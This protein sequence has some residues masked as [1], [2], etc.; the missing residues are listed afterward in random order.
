[1]EISFAGR[2]GGQGIQTV[3]KQQSRKEILEEKLGRVEELWY[4][5][6][7]GGQCLRW[8]REAAFP[9]KTV[10]QGHLKKKVIATHARV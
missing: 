1:M 9:S 5:L 3:E 6:K 7:E 8:F 2:L 4:V 10:K